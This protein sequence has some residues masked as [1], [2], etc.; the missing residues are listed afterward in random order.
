MSKLELTIDQ[1]RDH[2]VFA[3]SK[4]T[5]Q[6][7]LDWAQ[8]MQLEDVLRAKA[9]ECEQWVKAGG[10]QKL[11]VDPDA[12]CHVR[13]ETANRGTNGQIWLIF[14]KPTDRESI[15]HQGAIALANQLY[16][17]LQESWQ[18]LAQNWDQIKV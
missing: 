16:T 2:V 15:P 13:W 1:D 10:Q 17:A 6:L 3:F 12:G 14:Q 8:A 7:P 4:R 5:S 18:H 9:K 11:I